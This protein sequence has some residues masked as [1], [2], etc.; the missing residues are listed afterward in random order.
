MPGIVGLITQRPREHAEQEVLRMLAAM[1]HDPAYTSGT[2]F[3]ESVGLYVG[4]VARKGSFA[5]GMPLHNERGDVL[6][7]SG[8]EY[9]DSGITCRL[10]KLGH[11][12]EPEGPSYLVHLYEEDSSFPAC[13]NGRFHGLLFDSNLRTAT[14]FNDRFGV[15][16]I[17]YHESKDGFYFAAETKA[18]L[19]VRRELRAVDVQGLGELVSLGCVLENRTL[20]QKIFVLAPAS[21]WIF[22]DGS[23]EKKTS[24]FQPA[25]WENQNPLDG[26]SYYQ[27]L[28][29]V[30]SQ[31]LPR[32]FQGRENVGVSL[33]GG[34]DTRMIMAWHRPQANSMPCYTFGGMFRDSEDVRIA[35][36]VAH[37]CQQPFELI[38]VG[39]DFLAKFPHYAERAVYMSDGCAGVKHAADL[40]VSERAAQIAPARMT[41]NYGSEVLRRLPSFKPAQPPAGLFPQDFLAHVQAAKSTYTRIVQGHAVSFIVFRQVPWHHYGLLGLEQTL[42]SVRSPF[43][44]NDVVRTAFRAPDAAV[45]K[46]NIFEDD[47]HCVRLIT[48][49]N[50]ALRNIRTD[51]GFAGPPG[52]LSAALSRGLLGF[53]FKAEYA[54]D[55]G[56]PQWFASIDHGLSL[57]HL[58]RLFL[59]RHKFNHFRTWYRDALSSYVRN[60]LLDSRTLSRSYLNRSGVE[61]VVQGH[62][63]GNRNYTTQIHQLLNL[64]LLHRLF[65]DAQ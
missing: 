14:L 52:R 56:M 10:K 63:K 40:Y 65:L 57:F 19:A 55:Y 18:I 41:G 64:E 17:Y 7:F 28:R 49:G 48:D 23:I 58:E 1:H 25:E 51:R 50:P 60:M 20:F 16:R 24:Y 53:T 37:T 33:T 2:W 3:D 38:T 47:D 43:L 4:W 42:L 12:V 36:K 35:R 32:Y 45:M 31:N 34:L 54:Y 8:E 62:L 6:I 11:D 30:F 26:E 9:P 44:D 15:H 61:S 13:L 46:N 27:A 21:A 39:T 22:R 29:D 5:D 59:G